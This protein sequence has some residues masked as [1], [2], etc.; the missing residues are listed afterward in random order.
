MHNKNPLL[1]GGKTVRTRNIFKMAVNKIA[2]EL[3]NEIDMS[4]HTRIARHIPRLA[5]ISL[6][7]YE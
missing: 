7:Y 2:E 6:N 4:E 3:M 5:E 1:V